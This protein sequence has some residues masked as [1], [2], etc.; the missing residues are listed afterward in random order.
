MCCKLVSFSMFNRRHHCRRCGRVV[1]GAC[2]TRRLKV[3]GYLGVPVRVCDDCHSATH[4]QDQKVEGYGDLPVRVCDNCLNQSQANLKSE[5]DDMDHEE[6]EEVD[7][8]DPDERLGNNGWWW[9]LSGDKAQ[10]ATV[11][12][13][14]S[15]EQS[16]SVS[17]C[18][19]ILKHHS[20][21]D[22]AHPRL[23]LDSAENLLS[24]LRPSSDALKSLNPEV[25]HALVIHMVRSLAVASKVLYSRIGVGAGVERCDKVI[26]RAG[27][28]NLLVR[29]GWAEAGVW[30]GALL[31]PNIGTPAAMMEDTRSGRSGS[32][33]KRRHHGLTSLRDRL[34]QEEQWELALEVAT[35]GG[36]GRAGI[37][38]AWGKACLRVGGWSRARLLF[39]RCLQKGGGSIE[40]PPAGALATTSSS[41][42]SEIIKILE[43]HNVALPILLEDPPSF[44]S[45]PYPSVLHSLASLDAISKGIILLP[46]APSQERPVGCGPP[47]QEDVKEECLFYLRT[48]GTDQMVVDFLLRHGEIKEALLHF[49]NTRMSPEIFLDEVYLRC[50]KMG[51]VTELEAEMKSVDPTLER[52]KPHL[53]CLCRLLERRGMLHILY[54]AQVF[55][56]DN[57]RAAMTCIRFYCNDVSSYSQMRQN[58]VHLHNAQKHM[59]DELASV[60]WVAE[61][62]TPQTVTSTLGRKTSEGSIKRSNS[63]SSILPL[64]L[65]PKDLDKH[66]N[67]IRRQDEVAK[68]LGNCEAAGTPVVKLATRLAEKSNKLKSLPT[69]FGSTLERVHLA[70]LAIICGKDVE[71]GFGIAFRIIQDFNLKAAG[72]FELAGKM[73]VAE[74][75]PKDLI[76]L[77]S[78]IQSSGISDCSSVCDQV[79]YSCILS[80]VKLWETGWDIAKS[81]EEE[82]NS[83]L[84][85]SSS[86][87]TLNPLVDPLLKIISDPE[88]KVSACIAC[89]QLKN[90]YLIAVRINS[91]SDVERI[92]DAAEKSGQS[93]IYRICQRRL[94]LVKVPPGIKH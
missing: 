9:K 1:C 40:G 21:G 29:S 25:D 58:C 16:P 61:V 54:T 39:A 75:R 79:A 51:W 31:E 84:E 5:E 60:G 55:S 94:Q 38:A 80:L 15:F 88:I 93:A 12:E 78:C 32:I 46:P 28:L 49:L 92:S 3:E 19:A 17:L 53:C 41:H 35:K 52:W 76:H 2:S 34:V 36:L 11:R 90:A 83:S 66:I 57:V 22:P 85:N 10:D 23:L 82:D 65:D 68:F 37:W 6:A 63:E 47:L 70:V 91:N 26:G 69:L 72:V 87:N 42:L 50:L 86:K 74:G 45:H 43:E 73:L 18:L 24:L 64:K 62:P 48:Y 8:E 27:L 77:I 4:C 81:A 30:A 71:E 67:T 7:E 14:F 59:E 89:G 44:S 20:P 13:E 56:E 33:S